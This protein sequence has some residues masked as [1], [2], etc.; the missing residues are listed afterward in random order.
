MAVIINNKAKPRFEFQLDG[1]GEIYSLPSFADLSLEQV[2][3]FRGMAGN[4]AEAFDGIIDFLEA[5]CPGLTEKL[6]SGGALALIRAW[7]EAS[8]IKLG[9]S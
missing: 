1:E 5:E 9:E 8:G 6:T 4:E 7:E 2:K 3:S